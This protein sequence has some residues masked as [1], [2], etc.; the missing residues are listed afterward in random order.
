MIAFATGAFIETL[1]M[2]DG[3]WRWVVTSFE[4]DT[5]I[6][7]EYV[8]VV[9]FANSEGEMISPLEDEG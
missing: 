1:Q 5:F 2:V 3:S 6:D 7:G 8:D 9:E 4:D